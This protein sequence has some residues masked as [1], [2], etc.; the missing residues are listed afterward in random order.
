M[1]N[2]GRI[3][4]ALGLA[5]MLAAGTVSGAMA[6]DGGHGGDGSHSHSDGKD[7]TAGKAAKDEKGTD[8][9][10]RRHDDCLDRAGALSKNGTA[11]CS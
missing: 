1:Q 10:R 7:G 9:S 6:R 4:L 5:A 3:Y 11:P 8:S 2:S